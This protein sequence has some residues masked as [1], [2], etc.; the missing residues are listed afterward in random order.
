MPNPARKKRYALTGALTDHHPHLG[1][2]TGADERMTVLSAVAAADR[3]AA[4]LRLVASS[5]MRLAVAAAFWCA[6][7]LIQLGVVMISYLVG[8][9]FDFAREGSL[10]VAG[11]LLAHEYLLIKRNGQPDELGTIELTAKDCAL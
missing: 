4:S 9:I 11:R 1:K 2:I 3:A 10:F 5:D 8:V 7:P 6:L